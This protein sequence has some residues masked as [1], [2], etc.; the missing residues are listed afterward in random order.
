MSLDTWEWMLTSQSSFSYHANL[1]SPRSQA[2]VWIL[3]LSEKQGPVILYTISIPHNF[4]QT[5]SR[6]KNS[7]HLSPLV[8]RLLQ[9]LLFPLKVKFS[10]FHTN[11]KDSTAY[12]FMYTASFQVFSLSAFLFIPSLSDLGMQAV[13]HFLMISL[14]RIGTLGS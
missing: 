3:S 8:G 6:N 4:T 7:R 10:S 2:A 1:H 11:L 9:F 14:T 5:C 12:S 13:F